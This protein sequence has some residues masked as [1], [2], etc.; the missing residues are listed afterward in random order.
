MEGR[1]EGRREWRETEKEGGTDNEFICLHLSSEHG[2]VSNRSCLTNLLETL[3]EWTEPLD[4]GY[5]LHA[6]FLD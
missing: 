3:E 2:F 4:E 1:K 5:G 6:M